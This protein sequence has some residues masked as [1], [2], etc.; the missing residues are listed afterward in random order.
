MEVADNYNATH[1]GAQS[2]AGRRTCFEIGGK[3][4]KVG[5]GWFERMEK[6]NKRQRRLGHFKIGVTSNGGSRSKVGTGW[7]ERM[8]KSNKR[9]RRSGHFKIG[10]L[11]SYIQWREQLVFQ[12]AFTFTNFSMMFL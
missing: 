6:S 4:S 2:P 11:N 9:Q 3:R 1:V 10:M 12:S 7:F 8:E 5:T